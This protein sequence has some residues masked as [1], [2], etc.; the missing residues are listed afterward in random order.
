MSTI[1]PSISVENERVYH[2]KVQNLLHKHKGL[3]LAAYYGRSSSTSS[4]PPAPPP[5]H[6]DNPSLIKMQYATERSII[7]RIISNERNAFLGGL[8]MTALAFASLRYGPGKLLTKLNPEK[9]RQIKEAEVL[10]DKSKSSLARWAQKSATFMFESMFGLFVGYRIGYTKLSTMTNDATYDEIAKLPLCAG[11][12]HVCEQACSDVVS[13]VH[14]EIP[15][16]FWSI[17]R[18]DVNAGGEKVTSRL[19]DPERWQ[20]IRHFADNCIKRQR[21]EESY[22]TQNGLG[23]D[24]IVNI[25]E[26]GVPR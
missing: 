20:A 17:V 2:N 9:A 4:H 23:K 25:P 6:D 10:A 24:A 5:Q 26:G 16:S 7:D 12:S 21:Y 19:R 18:D 1:P 3:L 13:L 11:R 8:G 15:D 14:N 22:R